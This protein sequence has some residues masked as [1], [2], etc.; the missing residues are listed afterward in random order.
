M[1]S[2]NLA[3]YSMYTLVSNAKVKSEGLTQTIR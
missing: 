1:Q 2:K 3:D